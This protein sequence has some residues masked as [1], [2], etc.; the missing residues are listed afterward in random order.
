M[1]PLSKPDRTDLAGLEEVIALY[2][3]SLRT[4]LPR[5][6]PTEYAPVDHNQFALSLSP[7]LL[8]LPFSVYMHFLQLPAAVA[9]LP[10]QVHLVYVNAREKT[11]RAALLCSVLFR[12]FASALLVTCRLRVARCT[13]LFALWW[14]WLVHLSGSCQSGGR[15]HLSR[16]L[17][18]ATR[19]RT[20]A[21]QT[22]RCVTVCQ[23]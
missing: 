9:H 15:C 6:D 22:E 7:L 23:S 20:R 11:R 18:R 10:F 2:P 8:S 21:A 17:P 3:C 16:R 12:S 14:P 1:E 4:L 13:L 5:I 19:R